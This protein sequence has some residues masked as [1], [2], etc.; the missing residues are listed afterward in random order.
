MERHSPKINDNLPCE[1]PD[2]PQ[3]KIYLPYIRKI[4]KNIKKVCPQNN[5]YVV[6]TNK[7]KIINLLHF[8]KDK[9]SVTHQRGVYQIPC[10]CGKFYVGKTHQNFEKRPQ[11][12][13]DS[14]AKA[15]ISNNITSISFDSAL[16]SHVFENPSH[17]ILFE[18][19][20]IIS[21][22]L[23]IKQV[24]REAIEIRLEINNNISF[25]RDLGE[26]SLNAL[27][28]NLIK[29]YLTKY[30]IKPIDI[31]IEPDSNRTIRSAAKIARLA[32]KTC[33]QI[34]FFHF[35]ELLGFITIYFV[36]LVKL[37]RS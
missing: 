28:T 24:V 32:L 29:S 23:G 9:T 20:A 35:I 4:T 36:V 12:H 13:K 22:D 37:C 14:I 2:N 19:S 7:L 26:C 33:F 3:N 5:M 31:N 16:S 17:K 18:E 10:D 6:F 30:F 1:N 8:D 15:Q 25:N 11:Q 27:Y 21:N 34:I